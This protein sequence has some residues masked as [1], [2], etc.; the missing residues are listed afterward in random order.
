MDTYAEMGYLRAF[1]DGVD[2]AITRELGSERVAYEEFLT[3]TLGRLLDAGSP[4]QSLLMYPV[5]KL[6]DDL[7]SCGSGRR[8]RA[9]RG[10]RA[11]G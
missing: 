5:A 9:R 10:L 7:A 4:F 1:F 8:I 3:P 6:N 11:C 2:F